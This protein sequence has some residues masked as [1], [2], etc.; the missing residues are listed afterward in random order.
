MPTN[1]LSP[2]SPTSASPVK[3]DWLDSG[4][5]NLLSRRGSQASNYGALGLR[6]QQ[7][8]PKP[9]LPDP[10][11]PAPRPTIPARP[12]ASQ[13][14]AAPPSPVPDPYRTPRSVLTGAQHGMNLVSLGNT[15]NAL[16]TP[17]AGAAKVP[18]L[19]AGLTAATTLV[20]IPRTAYDLVSGNDS[21]QNMHFRDME[22]IN[23]PEYTGKPGSFWGYSDA[24]SA[25]TLRPVASSAALLDGMADVGLR[26]PANALRQ[27]SLDRQ[28]A[29][30]TARHQADTQQAMQSG[31]ATRQQLIDEAIRLRQ[32]RANMQ[33][34][35]WN[36]IYW[37][38]S[39]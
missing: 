2:L 11:A 3:S 20:D 13:P 23:N 29:E 19:G 30:Q 24:V 36:P 14:A 33:P 38:M 25:N 31:T 26:N 6:L 5:T 39:Q 4:V 10:V 16:R 37:G 7:S 32:E 28:M 18:G 34:S 21:F 1:P 35:G 17:L 9:I 12:A 27:W 22:R 15:L 8:R